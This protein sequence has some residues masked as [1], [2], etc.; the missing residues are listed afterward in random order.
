MFVESIDDQCRGA[1]ATSQEY[2]PD[3]HQAKIILC[4]EKVDG[5]VSISASADSEGNKK[6][7]A[8]VKVQSKDGQISASGSGSVSKDKEGKTSG[9]VKGKITVSF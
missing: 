6:A 8:K 9:E 4:G 7:E 2:S 5:K 1:L 3:H